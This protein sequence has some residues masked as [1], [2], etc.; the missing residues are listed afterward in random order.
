[1]NLITIQTSDTTSPGRGLSYNIEVEGVIRALDNPGVIPRDGTIAV[2]VLTFNESARVRVP[3]TVINSITDAEAIIRM[4]ESL[5]CEDLDS[6]T[7]PCPG[8]GTN[9]TDAIIAANNQLNRLEER[10]DA[11]RVLLLSTDGEPTNPDSGVG[12]SNAVRD[13]AAQDGVQ[14]ELDVILL[15]LNPKQDEDGLIELERNK[16]KVKKIVFPEPE[17]DLPGQT[18]VINGGPCNLP[19]ARSETALC[20]EGAFSNQADMFADIVDR[21]LRSD[22]SANSF[23]VTTEAD[24]PPNTPRSGDEPLSLRQAIELANCK[25][26]SVTITFAPN[27]KGKT[28]HLTSPL[29]A[30]NAPEIIIDGIDGCDAQSFRPDA[31]NCIPSVTI[32]GG[33]KF[34]DGI[35]IRSTSDVVRGL[36]IINFQR[37]GIAVDPI[38]P[39]G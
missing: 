37:A 21:I 18:F 35:V 14:A 7:E 15:G 28:I 33:E 31:P 4:V 39:Y 24:P 36:R 25:N 12:A 38:S 13:K 11:R 26:G 22:V 3:L 1:M 27:V 34:S 19:G 20:S 5:K 6:L 9:Y 16:E 23:I 30:I 8:G 10:R 2:T 29:P 32:D 17:S